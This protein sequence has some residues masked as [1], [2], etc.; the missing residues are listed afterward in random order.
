MNDDEECFWACIGQMPEDKLRRLV[1]A[2]WLDER[3]GEVG[4]ER[5]D[6]D[7]LYWDGKGMWHGA[8]EM[9]RCKPCSGT[10]RVSNGFAETAAALRA[11][12]DYV[13]YQ[14][15]TGW[16]EWWW[17]DRRNYDDDIPADHVPDHLPGDLFDAIPVVCEYI[18]SDGQLA[19]KRFDDA[20]EAVRLMCR[21]WCQVNRGMG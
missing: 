11:T 14:I 7:G 10:G 8:H 9:Y 16:G 21:A 2:D 15:H 12:K 20:A 17:Y 18:D 13:P 5:C 3:A 1:F 6:G 19:F 4:C